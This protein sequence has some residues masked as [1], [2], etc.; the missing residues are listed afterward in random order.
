MTGLDL[1]EEDFPAGL[2]FEAGDLGGGFYGVGGLG[3][4]G[5]EG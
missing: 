1:E 5:A 3:A 4:G 2:G